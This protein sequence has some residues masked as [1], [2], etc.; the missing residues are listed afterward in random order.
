MY[1]FI[2]AINCRRPKRSQIMQQFW[3]LMQLLFIDAFS[4]QICY[5]NSY[6]VSWLSLCFVF[7]N[8]R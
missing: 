5:E 4:P 8:I 2:A 1:G 3:P 6:F 7:S